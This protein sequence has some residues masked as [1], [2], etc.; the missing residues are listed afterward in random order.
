MGAFVT[1]A[2]VLSMI[3]LF[4]GNGL[5]GTRVPFALAEDGMMPRFLV[6]VHPRYGTPWIAILFCALIYTVF[7]LSAFAALVVID[8]F[9]NMLV[10]MAEF[11]A[12]WKLRFT[13]PDVKRNAVP[14]GWFGLTLVTLAPTLIIGLA[15][16]SQYVEEG[17]ASISWALVAMAIGVVLYFPIR[18]YVKPGVPDVDPFVASEGDD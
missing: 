8:V 11:F 14:G 17:M 10:L 7:S 15:I 4:I 3:G 2:A 18:K 9:L 16:Y 5:G 12:M 13:M 6:G 1:F